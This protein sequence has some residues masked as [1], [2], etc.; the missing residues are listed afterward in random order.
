MEMNNPGPE[1]YY[2]TSM[3]T[4]SLGEKTG[5]SQKRTAQGILKTL[6]GIQQKTGLKISSKMMRRYGN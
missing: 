2:G 3:G 6:E 4:Q 5:S 1:N